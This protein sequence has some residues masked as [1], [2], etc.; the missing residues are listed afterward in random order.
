MENVDALRQC[1]WPALRPPYD[2]ALYDAVHFVVS[3]VAVSG[4][5]ASGTIVRGTPDPSSDLDLVVL[6][7]HPVR[8]RIQQRF[9]TVPTEIF[10]NPMAAMESYLMRERTSGQPKMTHMVATGTIIL[11]LDEQIAALQTRAQHLLT[12]PPT[13]TPEQVT[14]MRYAAATWYE[15]AVDVIERDP[16]TATRLLNQAVDTMLH[17]LFWK[18]QRFVPREKE[19]MAHVR[20]IDMD[21]AT[22]AEQFFLA[23]EVHERMQLAGHIADRTIGVRGFFEWESTPE[24]V[25]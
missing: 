1:Q 23:A 3:H 6:H 15:D 21:I 18:A 10:V 11:A 20:A 4:I 9:N 19:L 7:R 24:Q 2:Q 8:Q 5:I 13:F 16:V 17:V 22:L 25:L 12:T 14:R